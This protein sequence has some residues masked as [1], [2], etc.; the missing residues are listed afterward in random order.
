MFAQVERSHLLSETRC[1]CRSP[2]AR[3]GRKGTWRVRER[4]CVWFESAQRALTL[5]LPAEDEMAS[6]L[7]SS[8]V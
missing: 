7:K 1:S 6:L 5:L 8:Q 4:E 2:G 3:K